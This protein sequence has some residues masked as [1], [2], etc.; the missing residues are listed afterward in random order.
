MAKTRVELYKDVD[1]DYWLRLGDD[2]ILVTEE[3]TPTTAMAEDHDA[4]DFTDAQRFHG[5]KRVTVGRW[6]GHE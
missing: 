1:G 4:L 2:V 5:L 3:G 6:F